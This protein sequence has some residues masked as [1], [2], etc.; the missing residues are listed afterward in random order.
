MKVSIC[1]DD[2]LELMMD[3]TRGARRVNDCPADMT[4]PLVDG[5]DRLMFISDK[6]L[7]AFKMK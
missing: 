3:A 7:Y 2:T 4:T 5:I 6:K 1:G